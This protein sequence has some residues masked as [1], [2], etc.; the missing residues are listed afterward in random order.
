MSRDSLGDRM[1]RQYE[2]RTRSYLPR[3]TY[4]IIRVDGKAFHT[5]TQKMERPFDKGL[6][7]VMDEV[8]KTLCEEIQGAE[9]AYVQSDEISV[10]L[11]DFERPTTEAWFDGNVQ[12][13]CSISAAIATAKFNDLTL[14]LFLNKKVER[15]YNDTLA[16]FD[17]RVFTIPDPIEVENY[18]I[19]RQQDAS[20][21]SIQMAA[22]SV[23]THAECH[24]KNM[25]NLHDMLH[26]KGIN[27]NNYSDREKRG[28]L[29][30]P[31]SVGVSFDT[32]P[33]IIQRGWIIEG[34]PIFTQE[35]EI[36]RN[37]IPKIGTTQDEEKKEV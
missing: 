14:D 9:F 26:E 24:N 21:N 19:W 6:M 1:K 13:M 27:W 20:R 37:L 28:G 11:T 18:F 34:A 17:S 35:R 22:R 31:S 36:L 4:T 29:I 7:T 15:F 5:W 3:R 16:L 10:L 25:N 2:N 12:K 23:Y 30:R 8:A 33:P 32:S